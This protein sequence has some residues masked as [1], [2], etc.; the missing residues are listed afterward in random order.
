MI[1]FSDADLVGVAQPHNDP[2]IIKCRIDVQNVKRVLI[3]PGRSTDIIYKNLFDKMKGVGIKRTGHPIYSFTGQP[4]W[5][6]GVAS[7]NVKLGPKTITVD[8]VVVDVE[9]PFNAILGWTWLG[10]MKAVPSTF[11]QKLKFVCNE[12]VVTVRGSQ[13][14]ARVC[15]KGAV[16]LTLTEKH[17]ET[18]DNADIQLSETVKF[19][20]TLLLS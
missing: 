1:S 2:L 5:P 17:P 18:I 13:S 15:F 8:F 7:P 10:V 11:H 9:A 12:G 16:S 3:N 4:I 19:N 20:Q 14:S 6:L